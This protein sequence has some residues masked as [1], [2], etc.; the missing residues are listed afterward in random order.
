MRRMSIDG[1]TL[2]FGAEEP[3]TVELIRQ[4]CV[5]T[6]RL[7]QEHWGLHTP[8]DC[9]VTIMTSW[10]GFAFHSAPWPWKVLLAVTLPLWA[11]RAWRIWPIAGGWEQRFG[12]RRA[13]GVKPPRLLK[14][15]DRR[16][17][18]RL[19]LEREN[20]DGRVQSI[21]CHELTHAFTSH[22]DLPTWL[23][24]GLAMLT[25]DK[26]FQESTVRDETLEMVERPSAMDNGRGRQRPRV[27][28]ED[29]LLEL[30]A[31]GYWLTR[32]T[33]ETQPGLLKDLLSGRHAQ[34]E[35]ERTIAGAYGK[36]LTE[37]WDE[38]DEVLV[39]HFRP[40]RSVV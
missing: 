14:R 25:V 35:L 36:S 19:F 39:S 32:Y 8:E 7:L 33:E 28:N 20:L 27:G 4:A 38:I 24:E 6:V 2:F 37:F 11:F 13:V 1:L 16:I 23:R 31:R 40:K 5:K 10:L 30:Y 26:F 17:G 15:A 9:R 29:A 12:R 34:N 18:D 3:H 21:T 22:L